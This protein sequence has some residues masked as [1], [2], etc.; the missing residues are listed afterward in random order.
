[1]TTADIALA[2]REGYGHIE[3][4]KRYTTLGMGTDQGKTSW[5]NGLLEML[6]ISRYGSG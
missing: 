6:S 5:T 1:V 4:T 3:L 2:Q